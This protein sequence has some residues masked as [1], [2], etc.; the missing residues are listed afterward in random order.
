MLSKDNGDLRGVDQKY[1]ADYTGTVFGHNK[2]M[3]KK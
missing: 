2:A 1:I 3:I